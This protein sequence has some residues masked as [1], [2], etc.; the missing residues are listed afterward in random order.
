VTVLSDH[1]H[2]LVHL[3]RAGPFGPFHS[4]KGRK[5]PFFFFFLNNFNFF[6]KR[7]GR[8]E[9]IINKNLRKTPLLT[10]K[11]SLDFTNAPQTLKSHTLNP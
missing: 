3:T 1:R 11:L 9:K 7:R 4:P 6:V 10:L 5:Q 8:V 2:E